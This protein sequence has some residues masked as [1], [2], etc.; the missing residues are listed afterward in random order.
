MELIAQGGGGDEK[1]QKRKYEACD[2]GKERGKKEIIK[3][4]KEETW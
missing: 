1:E 3:R 4:W 2:E